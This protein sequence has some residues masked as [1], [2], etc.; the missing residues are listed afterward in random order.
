MGWWIAMVD[1]SL[2]N[3]VGEFWE[4]PS[5]CGFSCSFNITYEAPGVFCR[6]LSHDEISIMPYDEQLFESGQ[7]WIFYESIRP[8]GEFVWGTDN[9]AFN[10][11]FTNM[12]AH[13]DS[14]TYAPTN[15]DQS[16][17]RGQ[18]CKFRDV[19]YEAQFFYGNNFEG[20]KYKYVWSDII[21]NSSTLEQMCS[22]TN[23]GA[24]SPDCENYA[25]NAATMSQ[26]FATR[27]Y[28]AGNWSKE[29]F[30]T[31]QQYPL[32]G[33]L[34][35]STYSQDR[36]ISLIVSEE[37]AQQIR[38][39]FSGVVLGFLLHSDQNKQTSI[40][41]EGKSIWYF[42]PFTL[43]TVYGPFL[44]LA[45]IS[46]L[47]GIHWAHRADIVRENKFSSLF[48][49]S[50]TREV[51]ATRTLSQQVLLCTKIKYDKTTGR[52][53]LFDQPTD[54]TSAY[55]LMIHSYILTMVDQKL[56]RQ[57]RRNQ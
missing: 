4:V 51:D 57:L 33:I 2:N 44:L 25:Q 46:G 39:A 16:P 17:P 13:W 47:Y 29:I 14:Q 45:L 35:Y 8:T 40:M 36:Q 34:D 49:S 15:V 42:H 6:D 38:D 11:S 19:T 31:W 5:E 56:T 18:S 22:W 37:V 55:W 41:V 28:G 53:V 27:F 48:I 26:A 3:V 23:P 52:L 20:S 50:R 7:E 1:H 10:F 32:L 12:S 24:L 21:S 54:D 9:S 30:A 43:W